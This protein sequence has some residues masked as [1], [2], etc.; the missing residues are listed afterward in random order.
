MVSFD[1]SRSLP[2]Q[3]NKGQHG[4]PMTGLLHCATRA[5]LDGFH[6]VPL[7]VL[8]CSWSSVGGGGYLLFLCL[9]VVE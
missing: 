7:L 3:K 6:L 8:L 9:V 4:R 2:T 1:Y 5:T